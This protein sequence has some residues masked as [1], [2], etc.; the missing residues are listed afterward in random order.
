MLQEEE[1]TQ[2]F[3]SKE[4]LLMANWKCGASRSLPI[5]EQSSWDGAAAKSRIF[6][7]AGWPD[8]PQPSK[9]KKAF[10]AY[11]AADPELKGSYK[12]PFADVVSGALKASTAGVNAAASRL[13]QTDIPDSV[14]ETARSVLDAYQKRMGKKT[15]KMQ[16][17]SK[18]I[19]I[20]IEKS[21][22]DGP[23]LDRDGNL[24]VHGYFT[25]DVE[26]EL[27]DIITKD[28]TERAIPKYRQWGNIRYMHQP[29]P[30]AKVT[31]IGKE[32]GLEWNEVEISV[33][34]PEAKF[35][36]DN[37]L[38]KALSVGIMI[39]FE[40][41]EFNENGGFIVNDY[42]LAEISLVDHPANYDARL[43]LDEE[44]AVP[45]THDLRSMISEHGFELVTKT[46]SKQLIEAQPEVV[47]EP[48][49]IEEE[50]DISVEINISE[51][52]TPAE[53]AVETETSEAELST[54][55]EAEAAAEPEVE[56]VVEAESEA[57]LESEEMFDSEKEDS[58]EDDFEEDDDDEFSAEATLEEPEIEEHAT[59]PEVE[60]DNSDVKTIEESRVINL[61]DEDIQKLA[62]AI[63][64]ASKAEAQAPEAEQPEVEAEEAQEETDLRALV[65]ALRS[66]VADLT[67]QVESLKKPA[68]RKGFVPETSTVAEELEQVEN[69]TEQKDS[70]GPLTKALRKYLSSNRGNGEIVS[71]S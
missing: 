67:A 10:L 54:E 63:L 30:V 21:K 32:D 41:I 68:G 69:E 60:I 43:F 22:K 25:S 34:D 33:V 28:A 35:Q 27:G 45:V 6:G 51:Q 14:K 12:L 42:I 59:E 58:D 3:L 15:M 70:E 18:Q 24:I 20:P 17:I 44:K 53:T 7:W 5:V 61:T 2:G 52:E 1:P 16:F 64:D 50:K 40:D 26:D 62:K 36:V 55:P 13:P 4:W 57:G 49:V 31:G 65:E 37:G 66:Q 39:K 23:S 19:G 47:V 56:E 11:D 29:R 46:L 38:L 8:N 9:A 71:R 48:E